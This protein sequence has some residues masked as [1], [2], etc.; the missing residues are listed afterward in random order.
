MSVTKQQKERDK[1]IRHL[2][3]YINSSDI[4]GPRIEQ[5]TDHFMRP[6]VEYFDEPESHVKL[7]LEHSPY[8]SMVYGYLMEMMAVTSWDAEQVTPVDEYLKQ[9]GWRE[10]PHG[11]RYLIALNESELQ[12]LEVTAVESGRWVEVRPYGTDAQPERIVERSG[13]ENL[14]IHDAIVARLVKL[15]KSHRF[16]S[17]LPLSFQSAHHLKEGLDA[18]SNDL[19]ALYEEA[20]AEDG[21]EGLVE[22]FSDDV[23]EERRL[24]IEETGFMCFAIDAL[25]TSNSGAP[26]LN[27]TDNERIVITKTRFPILG[28][29]ETIGAILNDQDDLIDDDETRW[30]W[31]KSDGSN[32]VLGVYG[33]FMQKVPLRK[34]L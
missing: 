26:Q 21:H 17:I 15:G 28:D 33:H 2:F 20:V 8:G 31:L 19:K 11:R 3:D 13:S 24:R 27:N 4:W 30:S 6:V 18:V 10:G 29:M 9:R 5:M 23:P 12:F 14:H 22:N 7:K 25:A 16:G 32:T 1:A 34:S